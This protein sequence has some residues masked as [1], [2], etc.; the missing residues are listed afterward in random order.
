MK[1]KEMFLDFLNVAFFILIVVFAIF[2]FVLWGYFDSFVELLKNLGPFIIFGAGLA[3]TLKIDAKRY[4]KRKAEGNLDI[5]LQL[6]YI[7]K[8]KTD[9]TIFGL[10]LLLCFIPLIMRGTVNLT[11]LFQAVMAFLIIM[12][13]R[14]SMFSKEQ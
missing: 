11:N 13:F 10:P 14:Q 3:I 6:T 4:K 5:M 12:L 8:I 2:F 1:A 7:D 9:I